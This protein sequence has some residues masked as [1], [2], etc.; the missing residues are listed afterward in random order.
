M[1][2]YHY[3]F[4]DARW[5][6]KA[7]ARDGHVG[8]CLPGRHGGGGRVTAPLPSWPGRLLRHHLLLV[9]RSHTSAMC[10]RLLWRRRQ[11]Q[12]RGSAA[13]AGVGWP[14][15]GAIIGVVGQRGGGGRDEQILP[16]ARHVHTHFEHLIIVRSGSL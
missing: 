7:L 6:R 5:R 12:V 3:H 13:A 1:Y 2:P 10:S 9:L 16:A 11:C 14:R 15:D 8:I 4:A